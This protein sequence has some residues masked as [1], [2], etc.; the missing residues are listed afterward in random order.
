[1]AVCVT[2]LAKPMVEDDP[3][4]NAPT[5]PSTLPR[6]CLS[7][8]IARVRADYVADLMPKHRCEFVFAVKERKDALGYEDVGVRRRPGIN[9]GLIDNNEGIGTARR[10]EIAP[11]S[12]RR[13][14]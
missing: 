2:A 1:M 5:I 8:S 7:D 6:R 12:A 14:Q 9:N 13:L 10:A 11:A 3:V 4:A